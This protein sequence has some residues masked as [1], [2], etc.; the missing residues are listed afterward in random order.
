M[1]NLNLKGETTMTVH[2]NTRLF[3]ATKLEIFEKHYKLRVKVTDL[4]REYK[5]S[6]VLIYRVL[7]QV[8]AKQYFP[9][10][11]INL[12]YRSIRYGLKR[13]AKIEKQIE[14]R[15]KS[16]AK[17]YNKSYPGEMVHVDTTRL[18]RLKGESQMIQPQYLFVG[19][20]DFSRELYAAIMPDKTSI[21]SQR[22]LQQ[23]LEE[24]PYTIECVYSDNGTEYK[25]KVPNHPFALTCA[26]HGISQRFTKVK[27]PYTNGKA[28]RVIR[29]LR[30]M[31]HEK[32]EFSSHEHRIIS[33][34]RFINFYNTVKPHVSLKGKT[35]Y[36]VLYNY[37]YQGAQD[38][39]TSLKSVNNA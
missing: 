7:K 33:L 26:V 21:S 10:K 18:P 25:G 22:F 2:K 30:E 37:F 19:I 4:A 27:H 24:C 35:P 15:L 5:V 32:Q 31:W 16:Q 28:E 17:R 6:R 14:A 3:P 34:N 1:Y 12:R 8:R 13:L 9:V 11:S 36:E 38:D 23:M 29:T 20:D 39:V